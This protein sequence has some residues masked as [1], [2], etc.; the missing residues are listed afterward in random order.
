METQQCVGP[1]K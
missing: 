1:T